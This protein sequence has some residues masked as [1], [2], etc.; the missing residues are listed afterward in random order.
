MKYKVL[1]LAAI[2]LGSLLVFSQAFAATGFVTSPLV[3]SPEH[4]KNGDTVTL[5]ALFYNADAKP[6]IGKI[7][8]YDG[9]VLLA[10]KAVT[11]LPGQVETT[12]TSFT[13]EPGDHD[14]SAS[15]HTLAELTNSDQSGA[16]TVKLPTIFVSAK[17]SLSAQAG[18]ASSLPSEQAILDQIDRAEKSVLGVVPSSA[19]DAIA[20]AAGGIE[21]WRTENGK[22]FSAS[23]DDTKTLI[24]KKVPV[25]KQT[26]AGGTVLGTAGSKAAPAAEKTESAAGPMTYVSF[27]FF[28]ALA[29]LLSNAFVFYIAGIFLIFIILRF[30]Y[31]K[32]SRRVRSRGAKKA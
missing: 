27:G 23:R 12:S 3:L 8:F 32:I 6:L 11:I 9:N 28:G 10:N 16:E 22:R 29:F 18:D 14:F 19:K 17:S 20:R 15:M 26:V 7:F 4:P 5:S 21:A 31:R 1:P 2:I 13:I 24:D 25:P 30:I